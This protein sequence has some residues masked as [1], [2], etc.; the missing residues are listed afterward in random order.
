MKRI[1]VCLYI[2]WLALSSAF[3]EWP[4]QWTLETGKIIAGKYVKH[5]EDTLELVDEH[6]RIIKI[7]IP[8]LTIEDARVL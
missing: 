2:A 6:G 5:Y 1:L 8:L 7:D 4:T 3:A